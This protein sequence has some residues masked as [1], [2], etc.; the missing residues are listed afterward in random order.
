ML[1]LRCPA[2]QHLHPHM[3]HL[4]TQP[5]HHSPTHSSPYLIYIRPAAPFRLPGHRI[6]APVVSPACHAPAIALIIVALR[7]RWRGLLR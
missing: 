2:A 6:L 4:P 1:L 7:L 5:A 3:T